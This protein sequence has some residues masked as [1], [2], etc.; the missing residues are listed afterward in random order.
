MSIVVPTTVRTRTTPAS[1][2]CVPDCDAM[3]AGFAKV[4]TASARYGPTTHRPRT[5][6]AAG[7]ARDRH[8]SVSASAPRVIGTAQPWSPGRQ[9][10]SQVPRTRLR[11]A[12]PSAPHA[13]ATATATPE[14]RPTIAAATR[15]TA[16]DSPTVARVTP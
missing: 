4:E 10:A 2:R 11:A 15:S 13:I 12:E 9:T 6:G 16:T 3:N 14:V 5:A 8:A 7:S 1:T